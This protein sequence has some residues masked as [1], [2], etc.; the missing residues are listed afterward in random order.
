MYAS[1]DLKGITVE[2]ATEEF[3]EGKSVVLTLKD[4]GG[5]EMSWEML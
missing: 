3:A 2:H 4:A 1:H 5:V